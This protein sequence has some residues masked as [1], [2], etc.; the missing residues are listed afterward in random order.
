MSFWNAQAVTRKYDS[1]WCHLAAPE[2]MLTLQIVDL[3]A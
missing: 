2:A 3:A 1:V